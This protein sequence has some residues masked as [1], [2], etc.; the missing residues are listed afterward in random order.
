M[1]PGLLLICV[2]MKHSAKSAIV[3][4]SGFLNFHSASVQKK[5]ELFVRVKRLCLAD[6]DIISVRFVFDETQPAA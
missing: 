1:L 3:I 6:G 5:L 2:I 4:E